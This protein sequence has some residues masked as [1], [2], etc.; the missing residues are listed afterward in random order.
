MD[1]ISKQHRKRLRTIG[2]QLKPI[3]TVAQ[4]GLTSN[5]VDELQRALTDHEL[6][7]VKVVVGD[8]DANAMAVQE[9]ERLLPAT[10]IQKIGHIAL[11]Y[12]ASKTPDP[13]LSNIL[14]LGK[15][16]F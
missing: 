13:K 5:V 16:S 10:C 8:R 15:T 12:R 2:H 3:V 9:I 11:L 4:K 7:K 14:R 6:I 1:E